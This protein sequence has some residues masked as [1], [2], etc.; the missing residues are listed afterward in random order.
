MSDKV[1]DL[2]NLI[3]RAVRTARALLAWSREDLAKAAGLRVSAIAD[4]ERGRGRLGDSGRKVWEALEHAGIEILANGTVVGPPVPGLVGSDEPG[5]PHAWMTAKDLASWADGPEGT[6]RFPKLILSLVRATHGA[7]VRLRFPSEEATWHPGLDGYT[8]TDTGSNYVPKGE[9]AWEIGTQSDRITSKANGDYKKRTKPPAAPEPASSTFVF[10]TPRHWT[11][12][13]AWVKAR[14]QENQWRD[15]QAY[16][17]TDLIHWIEQT[18]AVGLWLACAIGKRPPGTLELVEVWEEWSEAT[19]TPL[20][21]DLVLSDRDQDAA[22]VL[23]WLR[24]PPVVLNLQATTAAEVV[25]FFHAALQELPEGVQEAYRTRCLVVTTVEAARELRT[26]PAPLILVMMEP[27][28]GVAQTLARRGHYILQAHDERWEG[29]DTTRVL[30]RPSRDGIS[31][32]LEDAGFSYDRAR[33]LARDSARSLTVLRRLLPGAPGRRPSWADRPPRAL[34]AALLVGGW[35]EENE[36]DRACLAALAGAPYDAVVA[37]LSPYIDGLDAPLQRIGSLW[38]VASPR[39]AWTLLAP[40]LTKA[41]LDRFES[42]TYAVLGAMDPRFEMAPDERWQAALHNIQPLHSALMRRGIGDVLVSLAVWG[43]RI[44]TVSDA[45]GRPRTIVRKLLHGADAK[46]WWSLSGDFRPLAE[47]APEA[48]LDAVEHSLDQD[49]PPVGVL[50]GRDKKALGGTEHLSVLMWGLESL[51]WSPAWLSRVSH[52]LARLDALDIQPRRLVNG[53]GHSLGTIYLIPLPHTEAPLSQRLKILDKMAERQPDAAWKLMLRILPRG[54]STMASPTAKLRWRDASGETEENTDDLIVQGCTEVSGRLLTHV[55]LQADRWSQLLDR[56]SDLWPDPNG[57][58]DALDAAEPQI[59]DLAERSVIWAKLRE[60]LHHHRRSPGAEWSLPELFLVRMD[61]VYG[62]F[63][64]EDLID[65]LAWLFSEGAHLPTF[66]ADPEI[67]W[68]VERRAI[69]AARQDAARALHAQRGLEALLKLARR[70]EVPA[71]VGKALAEIGLPERDVLALIE[72]TVR[73]D[74]AKEQLV[75]RG[76]V[77]TSH[78]ERGQSWSMDLLVRA[79]AEGWNDR[80]LVIVLCALPTE[81]WVWDQAAHVGGEPERAYWRQAPYSWRSDDPDEAAHIIRTSIAM[82]F[83]RHILVARCADE[84]RL[85]SDLLVEL[86]N[87]A[88]APLPEEDDAR[89]DLSRIQGGVVRILKALDHRDDVSRDVIAGLEWRYLPLLEH[90]QRPPSAL[91][92]KLSEQP[93]FFVELLTATFKASEESGVVDPEPPDLDH[94]RTIR[95]QAYRLFEIWNRIPGSKEDGT[96][97]GHALDAW[98]AEVRTMAKVAG[99]ED[100]ANGRF[101][102][103]LS[104]SPMGADGHWPAET[105]RNLLER[106]HAIARLVSGFLTGKHN[107]R[108]V[109]TRMP[110]DGGALERREAAKYRA[111]AKGIED[112][113]PRTAKLLVGMAE[114]YDDQARRE[115]ES[116]DRLDW[117]E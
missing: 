36:A 56:V 69:D 17:A 3:P 6:G 33:N 43:A 82:G 106:D 89:N 30:A 109:T 86:L 4:F 73:S 40:R 9:A 27:E 48:F 14:R 114:T 110:R 91:M 96:I 37:E 7:A 19:A 25:A 45:A 85:P 100:A 80:A 90:S 107:R 5:M 93:A 49:D 103:V 28:S 18:H 47:A 105:V 61:R 75:G 42:A 70:T 94:A 8:S 31:S 55:G 66:D 113:H 112:E 63:T 12:K 46:R 67:R 117:H 95:D 2:T 77:F 88:V 38:R 59:H 104:T 81:R 35:H 29:T 53:P 32:A 102:L 24:G 16:D 108:G 76:L 60:V 23:R 57:L 15:V 101:G 20:T 41:D 13:E 62:R 98:I 51:A 54:S 87:A 111:W 72:A 97:D 115:D 84:V 74:D 21:E 34:L 71:Y 1:P 52:V 11:T 26:A 116:A 99:R 58:L 39:D 65:R 79:Q 50:F 44:P 78:R 22:A 64:P 92:K 68:D 83:A 10:V